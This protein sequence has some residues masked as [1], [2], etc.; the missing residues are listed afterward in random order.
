MKTCKSLVSN[1]HTS[2][3]LKSLLGKEE[4]FLTDA[5]NQA[6]K[7]GGIVSYIL[8]HCVFIVYAFHNSKAKTINIAKDN[9]ATVFWKIVNGNFVEKCSN[10]RLAPHPIVHSATMIPS[11]R[12]W[13]LP[14]L[15][16]S[17]SP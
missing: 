6:D 12:Y 16:N 2:D 14:W 9:I 15:E 10:I 17:A 5:L 3:N 7:N 8:Y 1:N 11:I 4:V 13:S